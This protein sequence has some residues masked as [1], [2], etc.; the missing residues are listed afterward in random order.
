MYG[1]QVTLSVNINQFVYMAGVYHGDWL[2][3]RLFVLPSLSRFHLFLTVVI[4]VSKPVL[5]NF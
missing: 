2:S 3:R 5:E 4:N 1:N